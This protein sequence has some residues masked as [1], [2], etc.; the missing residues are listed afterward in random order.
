MVAEGDVV[1][2][3]ITTFLLEKTRV[4]A[5]AADERTYHAFYQLLKGRGGAAAA[6]A[7]LKETKGAGAGDVFNLEEW[8]N[9]QNVTFPYLT[10]GLR[11]IPNVD[12]AADFTHLQ[13]A[14]RLFVD[15]KSE[16]AIVRLL[17]AVLF[18][19]RL[20]LAED[21]EGNAR[22]VEGDELNVTAELLG[23]DADALCFALTSR[24]VQG[25]GRVSIAVK[26]LD[27]AAARVA[28]ATL[29]KASYAGLFLKLVATMN[30]V[31]KPKGHGGR[32][33]LKIGTLDICEF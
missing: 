21:K 7:A 17:T 23:V 19:G 25:G 10:H 33:L 2:S 8:A 9:A 28:Q 4:V 30:R 29:A 32:D 18:L 20:S 14:L 12:D 24:Q 31:M 27:A 1:G 3:T 6:E 15:G 5:Q 16:A 22:V 11:A 13:S 26:R